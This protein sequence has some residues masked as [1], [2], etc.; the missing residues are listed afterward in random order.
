M[1]S[2]KQ[3]TFIKSC[4]L[5]GTVSVE[6]IDGQTLYVV[7]SQELPDLLI[8]S[9][10]HV[11]TFGSDI[12][13]QYTLSVGEDVFLT[14]THNI[15]SKKPE[16]AEVRTILNLLDTCS[17]MLMYQESHAKKRGFIASFTIGTQRS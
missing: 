17:S 11:G 8:I 10:M 7:D 2:R 5:Y 6:H 12:I 15:M 13:M 1:L 9:I 16:N 14:A 3:L 4:I